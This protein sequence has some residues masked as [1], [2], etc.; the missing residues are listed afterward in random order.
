MKQMPIGDDT[1]EL[2]TEI[3]N[4]NPFELTSALRRAGCFVYILIPQDIVEYH[5]DGHAVQ[6]GEKIVSI[7][8]VK[9]ALERSQWAMADIPSMGELCECVL[10]TARNIR[11]E[12]AKGKK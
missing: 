9:N 6:D 11:E 3:A 4:S 8:E 12:K 10:D 2:L 1:K 7:P 5:A